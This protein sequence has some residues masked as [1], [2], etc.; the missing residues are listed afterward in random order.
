MFPICLFYIYFQSV[1]RRALINFTNQYLVWIFSS[2]FKES[3]WLIILGYCCDWSAT[4]FVF[5]CAKYFN[6]LVVDL[7][8]TLMTARVEDMNLDDDHDE[9]D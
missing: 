5:S 7:I 6:T 9:C 1:Q 4:L 3:I 2:L 8:Y